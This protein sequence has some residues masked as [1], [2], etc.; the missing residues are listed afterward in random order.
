MTLTIEHVWIILVWLG[1]WA[2]ILSKNNH[3]LII[4]I[5]LCVPKLIRMPGRKLL[6]LSKNNKFV[7][8][9]RISVKW[10]FK[11]FAFRSF[12]GF[13]G[14]VRV[15]V[16]KTFVDVWVLI[17]L[18]LFVCID[19]TR[20][21]NFI[22]FFADRTAIWADFFMWFTKFPLTLIRREVLSRI[23]KENWPMLNLSFF[24]Y[25]LFIWHTNWK[26]IP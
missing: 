17:C 10:K 18:N 22:Y 25:A 15:I 9:T 5:L 16:P 1:I 6:V 12:G 20:N 11:C 3:S 4:W 23:G 24:N 26:W 21:R 13:V 7:I 14:Q 2:N 8:L 19:N